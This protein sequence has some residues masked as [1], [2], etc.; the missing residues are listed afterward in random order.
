MVNL[1]AG[2]Q[3]KTLPEGFQWLNEP[4][5]WC[6][7]D[8]GLVVQAETKTDFFRDPAGTSIK[9][10]GHFLYRHQAGDFTF[11]TRVQVEMLDDFDAA[12]LMVMVDDEHWAKLCCEFS[13]KRPMIVSVVTKGLSDDCNSV[14]LPE[15]GV[16]LRVT[17][18]GSC[19]AFH[20]SHDG[21]WWEMA[22]YFR[23]ESDGP[24]RVGL[25]AQSPTGNGCQVVF[26]NLQFS[27]TPIK[28]IRSGR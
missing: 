8:Q 25:V 2:L 3:G 1:F 18:F 13:Y 17:R 20:Y 11:S 7:T 12:V 26:E 16:Y 24:V 27:P 23:L 28:D 5:N 4:E 14:T 6:F 19:F 15:S 10:D 9:D 22:R 21:E